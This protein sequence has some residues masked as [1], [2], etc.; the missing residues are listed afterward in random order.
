MKDGW[1]PVK[2]FAQ[3]TER[4]PG[5]NAELCQRSI[6]H[7]FVIKSGPTMARMISDWIKRNKAS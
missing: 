1:V 6:D 3:L 2:Y 7:S 5:I 4:F